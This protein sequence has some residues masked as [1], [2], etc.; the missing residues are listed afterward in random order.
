MDCC[1]DPIRVPTRQQGTYL[2]PH[3]RRR[4]ISWCS[5]GHQNQDG[6]NS[7]SA[8][9][10]G[11]YWCRHVATVVLGSESIVNADIGLV[12]DQQ[13]RSYQTSH[14]DATRCKARHRYRPAERWTVHCKCCLCTDHASPTIL[15]L[16][17]TSAQASDHTVIL[18][19]RFGQTR[20]GRSKSFTFVLS[21]GWVCHKHIKV[22]TVVM[23]CPARV[24]S[25]VLYGVPVVR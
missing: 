18:H 21:L 8:A 4:R 1:I 14:R 2:T 7:N 3:C 6:R 16:V 20:S 9:V 24:S 10:A 11:E 15:D 13:N 23:S 19:T 17:V 22:V 25:T 12:G 5:V